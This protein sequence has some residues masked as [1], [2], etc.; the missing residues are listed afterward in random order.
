[1]NF[2]SY[3]GRWYEYMKRRKGYEVNGSKMKNDANMQRIG[4]CVGW[5][6]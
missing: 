4:V 5:M 2:L 3:F 1:M 6:K